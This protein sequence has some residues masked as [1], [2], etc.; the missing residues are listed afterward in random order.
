MVALLLPWLSAAADTEEVAPH[1]WLAKARE[2]HATND[3]DGAARYYNEIRFGSSHWPDKVIDFTRINILRRKPQEAFRMME[4][5]RTID[6]DEP[7]M[8]YYRALAF[9]LAKG[10]AAELPVE[11][12]RWKAL[13]N[14][15]ILRFN[16]R[17]RSREY[18]GAPLEQA[19]NG[20][21]QNHL[22][23]KQFHALEDIPEV[24]VLAGQGCRLYGSRL[25]DPVKAQQ[26]EYVALK[27]FHTL[28]KDPAFPPI[29]GEQQIRPRLLFLALK[30]AKKDDLLIDELISYY[31]DLPLQDWYKLHGDERRFIFK[32][33][34]SKE[35]YPKAP[36][37][38]ENAGFTFVIN[39]IKN[40]PP[41][42][43][44]IW[45]DLLDWKQVTIKD[46]EE[47]L[48]HFLTDDGLNA[49]PMCLMAR[50]E[51]YAQ[52]SDPTKALG[53]VRQLLINGESN[54]EMQVEQRAIDLGSQIFSEYRYDPR[55][56][57]GIQA[58]LPSALWPR[59]FRPVLID[60]SLTGHHER[61]ENAMAVL[62]KAGRSRSLGFSE[63]D[64]LLLR[65]LGSRNAGAVDKILRSWLKDRRL[66][67]NRMTFL[68]MLSERMMG[69]K[70][71][72]FQGLKTFSQLVAEVL[73]DFLERGQ[74]DERT[75]ELFAFYRTASS[76][77][78]IRGNETVRQG[79]VKAGTVN[80]RDEH[81]SPINVKWA[82]PD[83][84]NVR[85]LLVMPVSAVGRDW[86][87]Q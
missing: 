83:Q 43:G 1:Q 55:L 10:C 12:P 69:L 71:T 46:R 66:N 14:A 82:A 77:E 7:E 56:L 31:K 80:I 65:A 61:F 42:E 17:Y 47:I 87:I 52:A 40:I 6:I 51:L 33:L 19:I 73:K 67:N 35:V 28:G 21:R 38:T 70:D 20:T 9:L 13:M 25:Q 41:K 4:M 27:E 78:F 81:E 86:A 2:A 60:E 68:A 26:H 57:G 34:L 84:P 75:Q 62:N 23:A 79:L 30:H 58:A 18:S 63:D 45:L 76:E 36:I 48:D 85:E 39:M 8:K 29:T 32:T 49:R 24:R 15:H 44:V 16:A 50:A 53:I 74:N 54:G 64:L 22:G 37:P 3:M 72:D 11:N 5:L 59:V